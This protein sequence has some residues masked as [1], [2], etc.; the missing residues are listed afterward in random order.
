[1]RPKQQGQAPSSQPK[2]LPQKIP[3]GLVNPPR[4]FKEKRRTVR[5]TVVF[6]CLI[7]T[8]LF[9][10]SGQEPSYPGFKSA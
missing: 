2:L 7:V 5:N 10:E 6:L 1:M 8:L 4:R 3:S 9:G